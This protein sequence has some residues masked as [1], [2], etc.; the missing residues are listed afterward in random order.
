MSRYDDQPYQKYPD[1]CERCAGMMGGVRG[2]ENRHPEGVGYRVLCDYCSVE[3]DAGLD[4]DIICAGCDKPWSTHV[5]MELGQVEAIWKQGIEL[6]VCDQRDD[7][8]GIPEGTL[9]LMS[10]DDDRPGNPCDEEYMK[11]ISS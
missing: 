11:E 4:R 6:E 1:N 10:L 7:Y 8:E 5:M 9:Y 2:N 3:I